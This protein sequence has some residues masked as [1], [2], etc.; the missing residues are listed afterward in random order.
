MGGLTCCPCVRSRCLGVTGCPGSL[1]AVSWQPDVVSSLPR[2]SSGVTVRDGRLAPPRLT[3]GHISRI[4][5]ELWTV[6]IGAQSQ[7]GNNNKTKQKQTLPISGWCTP[8]AHKGRSAGAGV[9]R[10]KNSKAGRRRG[11]TSSAAQKGSGRTRRVNA[12]A[13]P[14]RF[15]FSRRG[16]SRSQL[17]SSSADAIIG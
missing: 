1:P 2:S 7:K 9:R 3:P 6:T 17:V 15:F 14:A 4:P 5:G 10:L 12:R 16:N 13:S 8:P 11:G